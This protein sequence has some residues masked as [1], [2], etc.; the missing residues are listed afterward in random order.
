MA[1]ITVDTRPTYLLD[2]VSSNGKTWRVVLAPH[3][4]TYDGRKIL[5]SGPLVEFYDAD[6][7]H[8]D[9]DRLRRPGDRR[10]DWSMHGQFVSSYCLD[11]MLER[12]PY[13]FNI[14]TG[15][16]AWTIDAH[17][18]L[19]ITRWLEQMST[20]LELRADDAVWPPVPEHLR[21]TVKA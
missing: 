21:T 1:G 16:P 2:V 9:P 17:T 5:E 3:G 19:M 20:R 18:M 6:Q 11:T 7:R 12:G 13:A 8:S 10:H 15:I 14:D 4:Y